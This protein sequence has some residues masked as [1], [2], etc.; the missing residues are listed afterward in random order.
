[1]DK[2]DQLSIFHLY[3]KDGTSIF[4]H[5]LSDKELLLKLGDSTVI[6]G[7]Y[8]H[9][10]RVESFTMFKNDL[11]RLIESA[12]KSWI[13]DTRFIPHFVLSAALFLVIYLLAALIIRD[14]IPMVDELLLA[15][16]GSIGMFFYLSKR[17]QNSEKASKK[18]LSLRLI[19]DRIVFVE[20]PF[21]KELEEILHYNES[22]DSKSLVESIL[23]EDEKGFR[24]GSSEDFMQLISYMDNYFTEKPYGKKIKRIEKLG[25]AKTSKWAEENKVDLSLF[26]IYR[27]LKKRIPLS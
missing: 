12:V 23:G 15:L 22:I 24:H 1:M 25:I 10:P 2:K 27:K 16:G 6:T 14:P 17:D 20:D 9:E 21:V 18:R 7:K 8:G 19:I 11:Y 13:S 5:P 3:R 4:L 26:A